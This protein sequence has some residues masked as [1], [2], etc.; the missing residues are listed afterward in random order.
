MWLERPGPRVTASEG[1]EMSPG[2]LRIA[3]RLDGER[4]ELVLSGEIDLQ[5][6]AQLQTCLQALPPECPE[7]VIDLAGVTFMDSSGLH[8]LHHA[9]RSLTADGRKLTV[10]NPTDAVRQVFLVTGME[11]SC[12]LVPQPGATA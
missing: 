10:S 5:T 6:C 1:A 8:A 12:G 7:V 2:V 4:L 3:R 9:H 11:E